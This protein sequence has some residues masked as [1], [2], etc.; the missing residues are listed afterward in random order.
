M[1]VFAR[2]NESVCMSCPVKEPREDQGQLQK[3][4]SAQIN[5]TSYTAD[6]LKII[7][8]YIQHINSNDGSIGMRNQAAGRCISQISLRDLL[9]ELVVWRSVILWI[10]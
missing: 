1:N 9:E 7:H 6:P 2:K 5:N 8:T 3:H 10:Q 4:K